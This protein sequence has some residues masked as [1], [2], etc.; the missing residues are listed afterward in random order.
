MLR[1]QRSQVRERGGKGARWGQ[2]EEESPPGQDKADPSTGRG[3][4]GGGLRRLGASLRAGFIL[5]YFASS[6]GLETLFPGG[7]KRPAVVASCPAGRAFRPQDSV[8]EAGASG[9]AGPGERR[10]ARPLITP[11]PLLTV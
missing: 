6:A 5:L 10:V 8:S 4:A 2:P 7:D 1:E 3:R 11:P 9:H